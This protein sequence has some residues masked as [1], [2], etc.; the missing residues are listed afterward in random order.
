MLASREERR[1]WT[2]KAFVKSIQVRVTYIPAHSYL[3]PRPNAP[4]SAQERVPCV[5]DLFS[6]VETSHWGMFREEVFP[7]QD[8][9]K[10]R[11]LKPCAFAKFCIAL[12]PCLLEEL[13]HLQLRIILFLS[14]PSPEKKV[15]RLPSNGRWS[16][17]LERLLT[18]GWPIR[19]EIGTDMEPNSR[20]I[21][22]MADSNQ[23]QGR[24][25]T[26]VTVKIDKSIFW[27]D[28]RLGWIHL[29]VISIKTRPSLE[30][31]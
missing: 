4:T 27:D 13:Y 20:R 16:T 2:F 7:L 23:K 5:L 24:V 3:H 15:P 31:S 29:L 25:D 22:T 19:C 28:T 10:N 30:H 12:A 6:H 8:R 17:D 9:D 26:H 21:S 11:G 18:H 14:H 1:R